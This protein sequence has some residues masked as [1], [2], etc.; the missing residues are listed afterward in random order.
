M[1]RRRLLTLMAAAWGL[2]VAGAVLLFA[3]ILPWL[4]HLLPA[5]PDSVDAAVALG[6]GLEL[7]TLF[8]LGLRMAAP[9]R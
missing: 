8:V 7:L 6:V 9:P 1:S 5:L 2:S 4:H 3:H